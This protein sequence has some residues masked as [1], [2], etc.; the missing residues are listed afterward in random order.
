MHSDTQTFVWKPRVGIHVI[1]I[2]HSLDACNNEQLMRSSRW[3]KKH[4]KTHRWL[5][6]HDSPLK[7]P[8]Q[9]QNF[10]SMHCAPSLRSFRLINSHVDTI[11]TTKIQKY[12]LRMTNTPLAR[13][14][15]ATQP[16][17]DGVF[18][19]VSFS[20][21][22]QHFISGVHE[23]NVANLLVIL[24][25]MSNGKIFFKSLLYTLTFAMAL[26]IFLF[27]SFLLALGNEH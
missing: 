4:C 3:L 19:F 17:T 7:E 10:N 23:T 20:S 6:F 9:S 26:S 22:I 2:D 13:I 11:Y 27:F 12:S 24:A 21:H 18:C 1:W 25:Q 15:I 5:K 8:Y 14:A 16:P